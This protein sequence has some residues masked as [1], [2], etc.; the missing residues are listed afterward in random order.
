MSTSVLTIAGVVVVG[1]LIAVAVFKAMWRVAEPNEAL[2]ISGARIREVDGGMGFR[3]VT[4][5]G[6]LVV[7]GVQVVRKLSLD[8]N[9]A[10]LAIHCVTKQ[11]IKVGVRGVVIFKVGD[12]DASISNAARRF[13]DHQDKMVHKIVN[14]FEGHLRSIIGSL[15]VEELVRERERLT[16]ETRAA[17][18]IELEKLG[19]VVDTLQIKELED[20]TGYIANLARPHA[21]EV[22]KFARIAE[23]VA[24]QEA[25]EAE[26]AA[27]AR[28]AEAVRA[29]KI[30][31]AQ[32]QAEVDQAA[33]TAQQAGP[34]AAAAARQ[35]VVVQ[36]TEVAKL[37]AARREQQLEAEV[38]RPA[39]A[40]RYKVEQEAQA[41]RTAAIAEAEAR[42]AAAI[43]AAQAEGERARIVG[44]S[45]KAR[46][47]AL[48]EAEAIEGARRG[49]AEKARRVAEAEATRAEGE[50]Q[51]AAIAAIGA[52]EAASIRAKGLSDAEAIER[53]AQALSTN[54]EAVVLQQIAE[55][56]PLIV[57]N[58]AKAFEG[59]DSMHV[60][61]GAEGVTQALTSV[62]GQGLAGLG[63][64]RSMLDRPEPARTNGA[65]TAP[66]PRTADKNGA[67]TPVER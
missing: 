36:E 25:T 51:A 59:V 47:S 30:A 66:A 46:R 1:L 62:I 19:L 53:R 24:N 42:K 33:S 29:S 6:T 39:D 32:F 37:E 23:A 8:I 49:D 5:G 9:E 18:G 13:L 64:V 3:V 7:P 38:R 2:I 17:A 40:A 15:T 22:G 35:Q 10:E 61:N 11:G 57:A 45:E 67:A 4:G 20:P 12:D 31:Q 21:A 65:V 60:L 52:A 50:A 56:F 28:Q 63:V 55:N 14:V 48:A 34:L 27:Q 58:A 26:A 41:S 54:S 44:E 43:A 16:Q